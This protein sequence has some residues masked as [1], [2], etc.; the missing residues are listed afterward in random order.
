MNFHCY[1][2]FLEMSSQKA[3]RRIIVED[4]DDDSKSTLS[5]K[6]S[7]RSPTFSNAT[8]DDNDVELLSSS[9][10]ME[11]GDVSDSASYS[12]ETINSMDLVE[13]SLVVKFRLSRHLTVCTERDRCSMRRMWFH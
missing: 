3:N 10:A 4:S 12:S 1:V 8:V 6:I 7:A 5:D 2:I 9:N 11:S 13:V